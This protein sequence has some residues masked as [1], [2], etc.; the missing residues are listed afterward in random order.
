MTRRN[1]LKTAGAAAIAG[2][3]A[4]FG[5]VAALIAKKYGLVPPGYHSPFGAGESLTYAAHRVLLSGS[6]LAREFRRDQ[7]SANFPAINTV[8]PEDPWYRREMQHAFREW[9]LDVDGLVD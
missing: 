4:G 6:Q 7:I 9:T 3:A 2:S 8:L 1:W 5:R